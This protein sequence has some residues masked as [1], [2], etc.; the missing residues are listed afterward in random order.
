VKLTVRAK[1]MRRHA[2]F[3]FSMQKNQRCALEIIF[4]RPHVAV[5]A[6]SLSCSTVRLLRLALRAA[7]GTAGFAQP[8]DE[9]AS[10]WKPLY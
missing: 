6:R 5:T 7:T 10:A 9:N 2:F 8:V 4:C 1:G 3:R